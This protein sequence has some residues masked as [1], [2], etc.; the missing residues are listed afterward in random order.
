MA[1]A[2]GDTVAARATNEDALTKLPKVEGN[3]VG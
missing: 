1:A 3:G 2:G